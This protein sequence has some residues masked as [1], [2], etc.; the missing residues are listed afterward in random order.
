MKHVTMTEVL[1]VPTLVT[2]IDAIVTIET[3]A[4]ADDAQA[5]VLDVMVNPIHIYP[6]NAMTNVQMLHA[7]DEM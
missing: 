5:I 1:D 7:V 4:A 2:T 6:S 3:T